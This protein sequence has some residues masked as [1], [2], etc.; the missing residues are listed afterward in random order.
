[1]FEVHVFQFNRQF[2]FLSEMEAKVRKSKSE[3]QGF[4]AISGKKGLILI[5]NGQ[6]SGD[7]GPFLKK[8]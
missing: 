7:F 6:K 2:L 5:E 3:R 4:L 1:L 8:L